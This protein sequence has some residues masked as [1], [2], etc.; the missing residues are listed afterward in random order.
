M[1][2]CRSQEKR[3]AEVIRPYGDNRPRET[4]VPNAFLDLRKDTL[5]R[6]PSLQEDNYEVYVL[7]VQVSNFES[8]HWSCNL[9]ILSPCT[10][11]ASK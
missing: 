7:N 5:G 8:L 1:M 2:L 3:S 9:Y 4:G 6:F 10:V 11:G